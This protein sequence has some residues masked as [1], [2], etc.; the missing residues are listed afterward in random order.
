VQQQRPALVEKLKEVDVAANKDAISISMILLL[1]KFFSYVFPEEF[2]L[3]F[4]NI[5]SGD[6]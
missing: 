4:Y 6:L 2:I 5:F 3:Q 1:S